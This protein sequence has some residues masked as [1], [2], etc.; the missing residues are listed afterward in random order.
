MTVNNAIHFILR[1]PALYFSPDYFKQYRELFKLFCVVPKRARGRYIS[2]D[3]RANIPVRSN[4]MNEQ[5]GQ[6]HKFT[7]T[8]WTQRLTI[9]SSNK[10]FT[11]SRLN[12]KPKKLISLTFGVRE[13]SC[14]EWFG[15]ATYLSFCSCPR[16]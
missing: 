2:D 3:V 1:P 12:I 5:T 15:G 10:T 11:P 7:P 14:I 4:N 16:Y 8:I 6:I 13:L 9:V